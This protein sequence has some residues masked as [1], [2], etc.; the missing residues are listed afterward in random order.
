[1]IQMTIINTIIEALRN[2]GYRCLGKKIILS[3]LL[4]QLDIVLF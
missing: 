1:M 4:N 2:Y 3:S